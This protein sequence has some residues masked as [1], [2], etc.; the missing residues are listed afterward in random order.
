[1]ISL[2][3]F[4]IAPTN[5]SYKPAYRNVGGVRHSKLIPWE[6]NSAGGCW[7]FQTSQALGTIYRVAI[8]I[9]FTRVEKGLC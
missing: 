6:A 1:M 9:G 7:A 5:E 2:N 3:Q 4:Q 8:G